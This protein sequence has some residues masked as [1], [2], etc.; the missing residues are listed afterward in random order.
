MLG[1]KLSWEGVETIRKALKRSVK[2][3]DAA[4]DLNVASAA[5]GDR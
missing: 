1:A 5:S 2:R 4:S 3:Y